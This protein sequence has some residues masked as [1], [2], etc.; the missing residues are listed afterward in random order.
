MTTTTQE[1]AP[2]A[3]SPLIQP[4]KEQKPTHELSAKAQIEE[5]MKSVKK[6][7]NQKSD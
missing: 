2:K 5:Y 1:I 4:S 6:I 7:V 3:K